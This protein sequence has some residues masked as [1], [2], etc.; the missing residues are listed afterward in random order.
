MIA[1]HNQHLLHEHL[2]A[3]GFI[4][5][6]LTMQ[7]T[8][9]SNLAYNAFVA[10]CLHDIG[11]LEPKFQSWLRKDLKKPQPI[12]DNECGV[13]IDSKGKFSFENHPR[14]NEI[15]LLIYHLLN[16][17]N[18]RDI[19]LA[20]KDMIRHCIY[21]HH[22]KPFRKKEMTVI[23]DIYTKLKRSYDDEAI[24][25]LSSDAL[26]IIDA[27][28]NVSRNYRANSINCFLGGFSDDHLYQMNKTPLPE[29]KM[30]TNNDDWDVYKRN[31][32]TNAK[33]NICRSAVISA[34]RIISKLSNESLQEH[35]SN[36]TLHTLLQPIDDI[37]YLSLAIDS[38]LRGFNNRHDTDLRR[39]SLQSAASSELMNDDVSVLSGAAG[40]GKTKVA[41]EWANKTQAKKIIWVCPR[42]QVCEGLLH[43]LKS[44]E[45]LYDCNVEINTGSHKKIYNMGMG[46]YKPQHNKVFS[47]DIVITTI[48]QIISSITTH[49]HVDSMI[50]FMNSHV[51]FD[52]YHE[53]VNTEG[54]NLFFAELV[55]CKSLQ[56]ES[57]T[58]L[59]SATP[60]YSYLKR[61]L[62]INS[63]DVVIVDSFNTNKFKVEFKYFTDKDI[64][65]NPLHHL[66]PKNT[67]VISNTVTTAQNS[68]IRNQ[69]H[70]NALLFHSKYTD[71]DRSELFDTIMTNF[72]RDG[73]KEFDVVRTSPILQASL[74]IS[75][76]KMVSEMTTAEDTLQRLGRLD[77]FGDNPD[78]NILTIVL[79]FSKKAGG[80]EC[81]RF[82]NSCNKYLSAKSWNDFIVNNL[83]G[84][85]TTLKDIYQSYIDF[86]N[87]GKC[88]EQVEKDLLKSLNDSV[89]IINDNITDPVS[90]NKDNDS[91]KSLIKTK[92][93]R[94]HN[95]FVQMAKCTIT[96]HDHY[97][98]ESEYVCDNENTMT[99]PISHI[100]G[101]TNS[102]NNLLYLMYKKHH[103]ITGG[104]KSYSDRELINDARSSDL[105]IY[106]SYTPDDLHKIGGESKR[107]GK[108]VYYAYGLRQPIGAYS[109]N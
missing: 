6:E 49:N 28:N 56:E 53:Y 102:R 108:A 15:S 59:V 45:Y 107:H 103:I 34:D 27:I 8:N 50:Q 81:G 26:L 80:S 77:R 30:Y 9:N 86:Y 5:S 64:D 75:L 91:D 13:H 25:K 74:N 42:V 37:N 18:Y 1:N 62:N 79:P 33:T 104:D 21:W 67:I 69:K 71:N 51:V 10:G 60:H 14:H 106:V 65:T 52:E 87:D 83:D 93:L 109:F 55:Q 38:C 84:K 41:L 82:L 88:R 72:G 2:F 3:V 89:K 63:E 97:I 66:Q 12:P 92:S 73:S 11:K 17:V 43:D 105:P 31:V 35:I 95:R 19:N 94:G 23:G 7:L 99:L 36:K 4:A 32:K 68:Y 24:N 98:F 70:E 44:S 48:D 101:Y 46:G 54:M 76:F 22:P 61:M 100:E 58:L 40:C 78:V 85:I 16:D 96:S 47:G 29:Y 20:N 90:H 57:N 39:N